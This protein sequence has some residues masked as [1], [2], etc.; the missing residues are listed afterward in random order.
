MRLIDQRLW[1]IAVG[2]I[3][4]E[5]SRLAPE[6]GVDHTLQSLFVQLLSVPS[7]A[8]LSPDNPLYHF[9]SFLFS[10][11]SCSVFRRHSQISA[12]F[13]SFFSSFLKSLNCHINPAPTLQ[14]FLLEKSPFASAPFFSCP[15]FLFM[16]CCCTPPTPAVLL[17]IASTSSLLPF[18]SVPSG[19]PKT[20]HFPSHLAAQYSS[21]PG[22]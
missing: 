18:L 16:P 5:K 12:H 1:E 2:E 14:I 19:C 3:W 21:F 22:W 15:L 4:R 17:P 10:Y 20:F 11:A 13:S 9:F 7:T 8:F 6:Q